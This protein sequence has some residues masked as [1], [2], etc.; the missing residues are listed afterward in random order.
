MKPRSPPARRRVHAA[1]LLLVAL[2]GAGCAVLHGTAEAPAVR[3]LRFEGVRSVDEA[4]LRARLATQPS[5]RKEARAFD[6]D[7]FAVDQR[8]V[9]AWYRARGYYQARVTGAEVVPSTRSRAGASPGGSAPGTGDQ[10]HVVDLT[11]R[12]EEG[13]VV[14]VGEVRLEGLAG[15]PEAAARLGKLPLR[16]GQPFDEDRYD[17]TKAFIEHTLQRTGYPRPQVQQQAQVDPAAGQAEVQYQVDPGGR[18]R[19]GSIFVSGTARVPRAV[20]RD[21]AGD[22]I[23]S[24]G[25]YDVDLLPRIQARVFAL[26]VFGGIRV[27]PGQPD[28]ARGTIPILVSVR[29]APFRTVRAGPSLGLDPSRVDAS[30]VAGWADR[31]WLGGLRQLKLDARV[32]WSWL[33]PALRFDP[34]NY[35]GLLAADFTQPGV[36]TRKVDLNTRA[37]LERRIEIG[38]RYWVER[39]RVGLPVRLWGSTLSLVPSA[40][41]EYYQTRGDSTQVELGAASQ[42]LLSCPA[43]AGADPAAWQLCLLS[44]LEQRADLDLRDDALETHR[45]VHLSLSLQE[46]LRLFGAGFRYLRFQ[47]EL[48]AFLPL[49]RTVLATRAR[50][51]LVRSY[52][53]DE[54]PIVAR[55]AS[56]GPGQMRGYYTRRLSPVVALSRGGF[57]PVGGTSMLDGSAEWRFPLTG[58]LGGVLFVDA[59][60]AYLAAGDL[61][62][63]DLLQ[64]APGI[65]MRYRS[66]LGPVR[67]DLSGRL[68]TRTPSGW[69]VPSV[70]VLRLGAGGKL[71]PTGERHSE[72]LLGVHLS[73]GEAF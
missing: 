8:R 23:E 1:A 12:V 33:Q 29:E 21:A 72:P 70:P 39:L 47:P 59:G 11:I 67:L 53:G 71:E 18:F 36:L 16:P 25:W 66:P 26:G 46:G 30:L 61:W 54:I 60:N 37:E 63:L 27:A 31:N 10:D 4:A 73:I 68:P 41:V 45:G 51:G 40:N 69:E 15:E 22:A 42:A 50:L 62:K 13:P 20:V 55:L 56:G 32:G 9:E 38:Y 2:A 44:Y 7:V 52:G 5:D 64:W 24:G 58:N 14:R 28:A 19:F 35:S 3:S 34:D 6:A 65:G 49:G 43:S 17:E 57:A 48:R